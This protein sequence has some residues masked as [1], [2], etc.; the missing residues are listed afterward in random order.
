LV[1]TTV[2]GE[3][4]IQG[5][6]QPGREGDPGN[7]NSLTLARDGTLYGTTYGQNQ[8]GTGA[9]HGGVFSLTPPSAPG[10]EWTYAFLRDFFPDHPDTLLILRD[11]NLYGAL[12][13]GNYAESGGAVFKL[14]PPFAPGGEWTTVIL[15]EFG[16]D[17]IAHQLVDP[18]AGWHILRHHCGHLYYFGH[19][20]RIQPQ[21]G[22]GR[23]RRAN[24]MLLRCTGL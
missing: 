18:L 11:G 13:S 20:D 8:E 10:G 6:M 1:E 19:R 3:T 14:K 23:P 7:P 24:G 5:C 16:N 12:S 22:I 4:L 2:E 17:Q 21:A 9:G 15:H